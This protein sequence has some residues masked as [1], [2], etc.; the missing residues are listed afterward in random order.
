MKD[1]KKTSLIFNSNGKENDRKWIQE[2]IKVS[3][4]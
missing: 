4:N 1:N 2:L 3:I